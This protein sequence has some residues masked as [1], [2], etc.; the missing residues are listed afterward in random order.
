MTET[1]RLSDNIPTFVGQMTRTNNLQLSV[2]T[3][4]STLRYTYW[5]WTSTESD[6]WKGFATEAADL[7]LI[8]DDPDKVTS[9]IRQKLRDL[10]KKVKAYDHDPISGHH[11]LDRVAALGTVDDCLTFNIKRSTSLAKTPI[12]GSGDPLTM[13]PRL[14][15]FQILKGMH[16]MDVDEPTLPPSRKKPEGVTATLIL[17]YIGTSAPTLPKQFWLVG[18]ANRGRFIYKIPDGE[19]S[20]SVKLYAYYCARYLTS[21]GKM[22]EMG[23]VIVME[24]IG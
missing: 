6:A 19:T 24:V 13:M 15:P 17:C 1:S 23:E 22:G 8:Y 18:A 7:F 20:G 9:G 4:P 12:H 5:G 16:V 11:L 21:T 3:P 14:K 2:L 10:I